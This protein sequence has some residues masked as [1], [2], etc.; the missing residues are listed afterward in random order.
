LVSLGP[1][2][3]LGVATAWA[4]RGKEY[5]RNFFAS[6]YPEGR[7]ALLDTVRAHADLKQ[8]EV[9]E[10]AL[11][12]DIRRANAIIDLT[13]KIE[14]LPDGRTKE[15]LRQQ[16]DASLGSFAGSSFTAIG[17]DDRRRLR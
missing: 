12:V 5:V 10:K 13:K 7:R 16:L 11:E 1:G 8:I 17:D 14:K 2:S 9:T 6:F 4:K 15:R 3:L